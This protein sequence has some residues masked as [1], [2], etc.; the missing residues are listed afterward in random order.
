MT[1][2]AAR[3]DAARQAIVR[4]AQRSGRSA[5]DVRLIA[6]TKGFGAQAVSAALDAG[7][8]DV[9]ESRVQEARRKRSELGNLGVDWHLLG[10]LQTNKAAQA[11]AT[12]DAVHSIDSERIA[13]A[14][15]TA[16]RDPGL[17]PLAVLVEVDMSGVAT[18]TGAG[19][20][21]AEA[22]VRACAGLTGI[23][24]IGLM[25]IAPPGDAGV[26]RAS[27]RRLRQIRDRLE[28]TTGVAMPEL[29]MGMS[30]DY[31]VAVEEGATM[32]R[33]GRALFGEPPTRI[34]ARP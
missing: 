22:L 14:L 6:V 33:L 17:G 10:H 28:V 16:P 27:F 34:L 13:A 8:T 24:L 2:T 18:R 7:V 5:A 1:V 19:A 12:F 32:V 30:N 26:A 29:S 25:T 23:H 4:A 20:A 15:A 21:E 9:G 11:A 31:Q 3:I